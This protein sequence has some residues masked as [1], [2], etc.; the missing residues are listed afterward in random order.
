MAGPLACV[1]FLKLCHREIYCIEFHVTWI[2][3]IN[4]EEYS[5]IASINERTTWGQRRKKL[6]IR[7]NDNSRISVL[8]ISLNL[9]S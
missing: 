1:H 6:E 3:R 9:S 4:W 5:C 2:E 7:G 8:K